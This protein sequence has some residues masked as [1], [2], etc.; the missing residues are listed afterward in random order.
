[1]ERFPQRLLNFLLP[2]LL[3]AGGAAVNGQ[4]PAARGVI[5]GTVRE[6][7]TRE[8]LPGVNLIVEGTSIGAASDIDGRFLIRG[9]PPGNYRVRASLIGYLTS[10]SAVLRVNAG[11]TTRLSFQLRESAI[12]VPEVVVTASKK[13]QSFLE[14]PVSLSVVNARQIEQQ[15]FVSLDRLLEFAPGVNLMGG[16]INIR[17]SSG[18]SRGAGTRVLLLVDGVPM[19]P[20]DSGD[21]KWD[22][23]PP[24]EVE[25]VEV[26]KGAASSLYGSNA[27]GG[28]VNIITKDPSEKPV[29]AV[30]T[31]TGIFDKP[32]YPEWRFT[33]R[34]L[35]YNYQDIS[36]SRAF[37]KLRVRASLGRRESTGYS[38]NGNYRRFNGYTKLKY[39]FTS[40][41]FLTAYANLANNYGGEAIAAQS[42]NE[43]T[44]VPEAS[45]GL[46]TH[47]RRLQ[48]GVTYQTL[49]GSNMTLR[50][51]D[52]FYY[53]RFENDLAETDPNP[54]V[55]NASPHIDSRAQKNDLEAQLD[56]ELN[57]VH[58]STVG[59]SGTLN[60][61]NST[62][63]GTHDGRDFS[64]YLQ[65]E[66]KARTA[67]TLTGSLRFDYHWVD[68]GL[69]EYH[70]NPRFGLV[71][72]VSPSASL[73]LSSGRGFR[74]ATMAELFTLTK[75]SGF[76]VIPNPNLSSEIGWSHE[77]GG[78]F[79]LSNIF[80]NPAV[81]WS[82]YED[83]IEG[84]FVTKR[85]QNVIQFQNFNRARIRGAE[86]DFN[87]SFWN[88]RLSLGGSYTY[89]DA[90]QLERR[91]DVTGVT[92]SSD[93]PL[94]YRPRH[95]LTGNATLTL[96]RYFLGVDSRYVSRVQ[97][98]VFPDQPNV[99][100]RVTNFSAGVRLAPAE[101]TLN[102]Y[103]A[104]DYYYTQ[105]ESNLEPIRSVA[106]TT[107]F[108]F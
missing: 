106:L 23:I 85:N 25:R 70:L 89:L 16:Q 105:V 32:R 26:V 30:K 103:N 3:L 65:H 19:L 68:T 52:S 93:E 76:V 33:E 11:D 75:A 97:F 2:A 81:F 67:L 100:Q 42:I 57:P 107:A 82:D 39:S 48:T 72:V 99:A 14:T 83:L 62:L 59:M 49:L 21:I 8:A 53:S 60:S 4:T 54:F 102:V 7:T 46:N 10:M 50:L 95:L 22:Q 34:T 98:C 6:A 101:I 92:E 27:L 84:R 104:F 86:L 79:V 9:V 56:I 38:Q 108:L 29:T 44:R 64:A 80:I 71:Y 5:A 43:I 74:A 73:R 77:I 78:Q 13:A 69:R 36:H 35:F 15:N 37:G 91:N 94:C 17:G 28:V 55:Q 40:T 31:S 66:W 58:S 61:I 18:Y 63:F 12:D 1:M 20:G 90:R 96:G 24:N 51:R 45:A 87:T 41:S 88:R 47:T